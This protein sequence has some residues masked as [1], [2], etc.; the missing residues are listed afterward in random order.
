MSLLECPVTT[1]LQR[2]MIWEV[3]IHVSMAVEGLDVIV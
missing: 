1:T 3:K 2:T